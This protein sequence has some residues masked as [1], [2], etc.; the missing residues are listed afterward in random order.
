MISEDKNKYV[1]FKLGSDF[2]GID[3]NNV[4]SIERVGRITRI[5]NSPEYVLGLMNLRGDVIPVVDL[6]LKLRLDTSDIN[7]NTRVIITKENESTVG[8]LVDSSSEVVEIDKDN[9]D[10]PPSSGSDNEI[11]KYIDGIGKSSNRLII[12]LSLKKILN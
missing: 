12:L 2:Y 9:I 10:K 5:P 4:L 8:L 6:R 1:I 11:L 3:V 7:K